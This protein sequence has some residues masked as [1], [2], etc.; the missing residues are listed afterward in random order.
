VQRHGEHVAQILRTLGIAVARQKRREH[1]PTPGESSE[2]RAVVGQ[3]AG[4]V[5]KDERRALASFEHADLA[6]TLG[7][8]HKV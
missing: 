4:A 5:Q 2:K 3:T 8:I 1:V 7:D 6:A